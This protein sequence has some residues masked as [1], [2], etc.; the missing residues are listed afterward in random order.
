MLRNGWPALYL[1]CLT[2][3]HFIPAPHRACTQPERRSLLSFLSNI[4]SPAERPLRWGAVADDCCLWEGVICDVDG[5][6]LRLRLPGRGLGGT[7]SSSLEGL[8]RLVE[9]N[10]SH[11]SLDGVLPQSLLW[12]DHIVILDVSFNRLHGQL[13]PPPPIE[14]SGQSSASASRP[15]QS[16]NVSSNRF[17][18][19][20]PK[21]PRLP[22]LRELNASN[23]SFSG[24]IPS[25]VCGLSPRLRILDFSHN[26]FADKIPPGLGYCS[27]LEVLDAGFNNLAGQLPVDLYDTAQLYRL[28]LPYNRL[29]GVLRG[30]LISRLTNLVVLDLGGNDLMGELPGGIGRLTNLQQLLLSDNRFNGTIPSELLSNCTKLRNLNLRS[31]HLTGDISAMDFS[32][33]SQLSTLDLGNNNFTARRFPMSIYSC[34][35]L[36]ALRLAGSSISG[37]LATEMLE[38]RSLAYLSLSNNKLKGIHQ[39][40]QILRRSKHLT[41]LLLA[42]NFDGEAMPDG[43]DAVGVDAFPNLRVLSFWGCRLTGRIPQWIAGLGNLEVL[44]LSGNQLA[45]R[46]PL[47]VGALP[48]LFYLDMSDNRLSGEIPSEMTGMKGLQSDPAAVQVDQSYLELPLFRHRGDNTSRLQYNQ[49][50]NLPPSLNLGNNS[51]SGTIP[52]EIGQLKRLVILDLSVNNFSG[53]IPEKLSDLS[54]LETLNL[55]GNRLS[56]PIPRALIRLNFLSV[57]SVANNN[58]S[59]PVPSERQFANFPNSSFAGNDDLCGPVL[60]RPCSTTSGAEHLPRQRRRRSKKL[61]LASLLITGLGVALISIL[62][63]FCMLSTKRG[64]HTGRRGFGFGVMD[65]EAISSASPISG[66][67]GGPA[68]DSRVVVLSPGILSKNMTVSEII[69]V[70][71]NFS[72]DNIVGCGGF[73]L[74]YKAKLRDGTELAIKKLT[75]EMGLMEREFAAEVEALSTAR[76]ENLVPLWGYCVHGSVR[77]LLYSYMQN[78]SLDFWLHEKDD[79]GSILDWPARLRI[80]QGVSQ[81]LAYIH[82]VC[83]PPIIHRDIKSSNILLDQEFNA[84]LA[85]FGLARLILPHK[86]HVSTELVGTLGY[87]PPEYGN[88]WVATLR[89][90]IYSFGV[91]LLELLTG[92]RPI[93]MRKPKQSNEL[94]GWVLEKRH[95]GEQEQVFD[96][97]LRGKGF[98]EQMSVVLGMACLCVSHNPSRRPMIREIVSQLAGVGADPCA[99]EQ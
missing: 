16:L 35:S 38:L 62:L 50:S 53:E 72:Q 27:E 55:S 31:N 86:T 60:L 75:G 18:G 39:A 83:D 89:G 65:A 77:L 56:G 14:N 90:D 54:D 40:L 36:T 80:A 30:E 17:T 4:S 61:L 2:I 84:H 46:I 57:F 52:P 81:G 67:H 51:L 21:L 33:F 74:V 6:V 15:I 98:E 92:R 66:L 7:I 34:R 11:N 9:L 82:L 13:L 76:H 42:W 73:G 28:A 1:L 94:V 96:P 32:P 25:S 12:M 37:S 78:G 79:G 64:R 19:E 49:V 68:R 44:D 22:H 58:L 85:D 97:Q 71:N 5:S 20:L 29:R 26:Q 95:Q 88:A 3:A 41:V 43:L 87:I 23:N 59:G 45:G 63:V 48:N 91:V 24:S 70:T 10:L 69:E 93:D 8:A 99:V 47:W